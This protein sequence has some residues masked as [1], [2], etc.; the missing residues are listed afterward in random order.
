MIKNTVLL[1]EPRIL[2]RLPEVIHEFHTYLQDEWNYVFYCGK[3]TTEYWKE[4]VGSYVELRELDV[5]N[6]PS[7]DEY[8]WFMKQ[9]DVWTSL[10]GEFV[11]SIQADT[12]IMS[13]EPYTIDYFL[14]LNKSYI[15]GNMGYTWNEMRRE[16]LHPPYR[17]FNGGLSLRKRLDM[18]RIIETFPP[19]P[20][21]SPPNT[22]TSDAEDVYFTIGCYRLGLP[23]GDDEA[24]SHFAV[25]NISKD[26]MFGIHQPTRSVND[27]YMRF[28]P[29]KGGRAPY[30]PGH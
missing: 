5:T 18:L 1:V 17:N 28:Y 8:N 20:A 24:S 10:E 26:K 6:F 3:G 27:T 11:L 22:F 23:V 13:I 4:K 29:E 19:T 21:N 9:A 2:E 12:W 14:H 25:H 7:A 15:G 16:Q 30:C